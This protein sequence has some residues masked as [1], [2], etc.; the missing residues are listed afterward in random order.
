VTCRY[1]DGKQERQVLHKGLNKEFTMICPC[2]ITDLPIPYA[3][4]EDPSGCMLA[5]IAMV[6]ETDYQTVRAGFA[7]SK[8]E[9]GI[10]HYEADQYLAERGWA[11][12]RKFETYQPPQDR[13][14]NE[15]RSEWPV[16]PFADRHI[17]V[18]TNISNTGSHAV[19]LLADGRV[20]DPWW[21]IIK[22]ISEY[23]RIYNIAAVTRI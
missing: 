12:A 10:D 4:Q 8:V 21:G 11:T 13:F 5:A 16:E 23:S 1:C 19:V 6:T 20:M 2:Q 14:K 7:E 22:S 3:L 18:V 15:H 9:H 17:C